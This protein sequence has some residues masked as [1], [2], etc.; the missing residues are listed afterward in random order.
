MGTNEVPLDIRG[1]RCPSCSLCAGVS[2]AGART[3][4]GL[5]T[6][7]NPLVSGHARGNPW[8]FVIIMEVNLKRLSTGVLA[9]L[10]AAGLGLNAVAAPAAPQGNTGHTVAATGDAMAAP[11]M[12]FGSPPSGQIPILYNDHHVYAKPSTLKQG[13]VLAAMVKNG[14]VL[15]PLRSMFEQMGA[16]VT[17]KGKSVTVSKAG[18]S[19]TVTVGKKTAV[20]N[21]QTRTL[22]VPPMMY[23]GVLMVPVRVLAETMSAYV[24]WVPEQHVVVVRYVVA[25]PPPPPPTPEPTVAPTMAPTPTPVPA[26]KPY[27][28]H[29]I[30]GDFISSPKVYNEFSPGN[31][32]NNTG[33]FSY[34]IHGAYEFN[35][36]NLPWML[37]G[38]YRQINYPHNCASA[39]DPQ[40]LVTGIGGNFQTSV[41]AFIVRDYDFDGRLGLK[42]ADPHLY[43]GVGYMYRSNNAGYPQLK[44]FGFGVDKL[45]DLNQPLSIYGSAWYYSNVKGTYNNPGSPSNGLS[46]SYNILKFQLGGMYSF[47]GNSPLLIDF[48]VLGET[49]Q[50]KTN[51][52]GN[53][54]NFGP[55][56]GLGLK[57]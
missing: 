33:G 23:K 47:T 18:A 56:I 30:A 57:F 52:P 17:V 51:A 34:G 32:G 7:P 39:G 43:V 13:R 19:A 26:A 50:G 53:F 24:Q 31:V 3:V 12:N 9:V 27:Q 8:C 49:G 21:G 22:D 41:P 11:A 6:G 36:F 16:T 46:L 42:V 55:Y 54:N 10:F 25:T 35:L 15:I 14:T 5:F 29:Y 1:P 38:D 4:V 20:I 2:H 44:N 28:D 45:P 40:C 48:G 37:E